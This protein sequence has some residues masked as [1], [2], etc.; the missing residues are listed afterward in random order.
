PLSRDFDRAAFEPDAASYAARKVLAAIPDAASVQAPDPL[1]PHVAERPI[2]RRAPPPE[3]GTDYVVLDVSHRERYA[4]SEDLLRT[5]EEPIV[6][7]WLARPDH[8]LLVYAPPYA[9]L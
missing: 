7:R 2:V 5:M 9:L 4:R 6:R 3:A 1:L 8:A